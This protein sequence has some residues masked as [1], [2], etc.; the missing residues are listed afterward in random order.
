MNKHPR[1]TQRSETSQRREAMKSWSEGASGRRALATVA[2]AVATAF[3]AGIALAVEQSGESKD[4][5]LVGHVGLQGRGAYQPNVITYPDGRTIAFAGLHS[6]PNLG[7][8]PGPLPNPL[9][10]GA[11]EDN[12]TMIIDITD[13]KKP[14]ETFHI[15]VPVTGGQAQMARLCLGSDL[16]GGTPGKVYLLRNIQGSTAAGYEVWDVTDIHAPVLLSA[17]RN[18]RSTHKDW[19]ECKTGIAYMPGSKDAT[20]G[21]PLWR[22]SQS[23]L[24]V[25]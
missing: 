24:I 10:G 16:P 9:N 17:L 8:A 14:V 6:A 11:L 5:T 13:P 22:E 7:G 19:W 23:M 12:G 20:R 1:I 15:P 2:L 21:K 4:M 25:D 3:G 18:L